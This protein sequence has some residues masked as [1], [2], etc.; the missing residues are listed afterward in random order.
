MQTSVLSL[1][2]RIK[3]RELH[4][5]AA[6]KKVDKTVEVFLS[7]SLQSANQLFISLIHNP[8]DLEILT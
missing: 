4:R 8:R 7:E 3:I 1:Q 5:D 6:Y 2:E